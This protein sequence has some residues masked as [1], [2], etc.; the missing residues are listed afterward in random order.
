MPSITRVSTRSFQRTQ[1]GC[2]NPDL[3]GLP[4]GC[5]MLN[6]DLK[7]QSTVVRR[8][9]DVGK[10]VLDCGHSMWKGVEAK[11]HAFSGESAS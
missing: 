7:N 8:C 11:V 4:K 6:R 9:E 3:G 2:V 10:N 5:H 1:E